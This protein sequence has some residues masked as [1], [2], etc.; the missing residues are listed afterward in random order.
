[1]NETVK[2]ISLNKN[3]FMSELHLRQ[4]GF[5]HSACGQFTKHGEKIQ[6]IKETGDS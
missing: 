3:K 6:T 4:P 5:T 1:M 2:N